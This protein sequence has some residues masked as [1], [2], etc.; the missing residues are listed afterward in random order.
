MTFMK[1]AFVVA[2]VLSSAWASCG[3]RTSL[4]TS[5][6]LPTF[7][8]DDVTGPLNWHNLN[9]AYYLCGNGTKQAPSV[10]SSGSTPSVSS[11][12]LKISIP[13]AKDLEFENLGTTVEVSSFDH[14]S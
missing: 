5:F 12:A 1:T 9:P 10:I 14:A 2:S 3:Y 11:S 4:V 7:N 13:K 6:T 8:Y